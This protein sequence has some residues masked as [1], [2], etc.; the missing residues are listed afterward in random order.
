MQLCELFHSA[1]IC[2]MLSAVLV[3]QAVAP[4]LITVLKEWHHPRLCM[5]TPPHPRYG[6]LNGQ[7]YF[8]TIVAYLPSSLGTD[9]QNW[10]CFINRGL[11]ACT[12][13]LGIAAQ[14]ALDQVKEAN[15]WDSLNYADMEVYLRVLSKFK[16]T[17]ITP[18]ACVR[19]ILTQN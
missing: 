7:S 10:L 18:V 6:G 13:Q 12:D 14:L 19:L 16:C 17:C 8:A 15:G 4:T 2:V 11:Q 1:T 5:F 9:D 3:L